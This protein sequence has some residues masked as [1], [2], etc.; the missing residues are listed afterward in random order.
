MRIEVSYTKIKY[1][2]Y[3]TLKLHV[4]NRTAVDNICIY[5]FI[6][7]VVSRSWHFMQIVCLADD[8]HKNSRLMFDEKNIKKIGMLSAQQIDDIFPRT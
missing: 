8:S 6:F 7:F 2:H 1:R 5:F 3:L 4:P